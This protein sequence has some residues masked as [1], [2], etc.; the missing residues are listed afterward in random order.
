MSTSLGKNVK[1]HLAVYCIAGKYHSVPPPLWVLGVFLG[2][3]R[4]G[5]LRVLWF[6]FKTIILEL[7]V[8][9]MK[10]TDLTYHPPK[11]H[12]LKSNCRIHIPAQA[13]FFFPC[14]FLNS[15]LNLQAVPT[16]IHY[17]LHQA[18]E[19]SIPTMTLSTV[20]F[21]RCKREHVIKN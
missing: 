10:T 2:Q 21:P 20:C 17:S 12:T 13:N 4:K 9:N 16:Y 18:F 3:T 6:L 15:I 11:R 8:F 19:F 7:Q 14:F 5:D 1:V